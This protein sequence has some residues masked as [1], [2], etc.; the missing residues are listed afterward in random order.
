MIRFYLSFWIL[1]ADPWYITASYLA[2]IHPT[3][4]NLSAYDGQFFEKIAL[5]Q[6]V[7]VL[8]RTLFM[9]NVE[10]VAI[11][12]SGKLLS[13]SAQYHTYQV[14]L[15]AIHFLFEK[16]KNTTIAMSSR[17]TQSSLH[18]KRW[19]KRLT[20]VRFARIPSLANSLMLQ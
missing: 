17:L 15:T 16:K 5:L 12:R 3:M 1:I 11:I 20:R 14:R 6:W 18:D 13:D 4:S 10:E 7:L 19:L 9:I 2:L 8:R